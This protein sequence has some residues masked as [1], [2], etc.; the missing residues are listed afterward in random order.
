MNVCCY[1]C[2]PGF[3]AGSDYEVLFCSGWRLL[4]AIYGFVDC[5]KPVLCRQYATGEILWKV[6]LGKHYRVIKTLPELLGIKS[7]Q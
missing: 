1:L 4:T 7:F 3:R 2:F 5:F 6:L